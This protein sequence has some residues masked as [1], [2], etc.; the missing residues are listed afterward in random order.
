MGHVSVSAEPALVSAGPW[1]GLDATASVE[2][3]T[4]RGVWGAARSGGPGGT[5]P[6]G[7]PGG[8]AEPALGM[9]QGG[10]LFDK[11]ELTKAAIKLPSVGD[12]TRS[13][14]QHPL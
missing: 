13:S 4:I 6:G 9:E 3:E 14:V 10:S 5:V 2:R 1:Q 7:W 11:S 8:F 12:N